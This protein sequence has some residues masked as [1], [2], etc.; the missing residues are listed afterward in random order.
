MKLIDKITLE[1]ITFYILVFSLLFLGVTTFIFALSCTSDLW[2]LLLCVT[3][4]GLILLGMATGCEVIFKKRELLTKAFAYCGIVTTKSIFNKLKATNILDKKDVVV[5]APEQTEIKTK[6][7]KKEE[8]SLDALLANLPTLHTLPQKNPTLQTKHIELDEELVENKEDNLSLPKISKEGNKPW[9]EYGNNVDV[10]PNFKKIAI[11]ISGMGFDVDA[12]NRVTKAFDSEVSISFS[13]YTTKA[14]DV[15]T[16][17]RQTGHET[18]VDMLLASKDFLVEDTGP[19]SINLNLSQDVILNRFNKTISKPAPIGG[20]IV[21]DGSFNE[22]FNVNMANLL[23]EAKN[24]GLLVVDAVSNEGLSKLKIDG[25]ARRKADLVIDKD[26]TKDAIED[27]IKTAENIAFD[28][29]QVLIVADPKPIIIVA[30][31]N[32]IKTFSPQISY[33]EAKTVEITKPFALVPLS[34]LVVE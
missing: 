4:I 28:K 8:F 34:N 16:T 22:A 33:E 12:V 21:R 25:L 20:I 10:Q 15:I 14:L 2:T 5:D 27:A 32:W 26:M 1:N 31:H 23:S 6:E 3:S 9:I 17:A 29:G 24:R 11:V 7:I 19:L 18:Y 13:P 30:L